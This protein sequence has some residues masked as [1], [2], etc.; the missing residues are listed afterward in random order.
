MFALHFEAHSTPSGGT[1]EDALVRRLADRWQLSASPS[2]VHWIP[3][4]LI[5]A[6]PRRAGKAWVLA[7]HPGHA[8]DV[9]LVH[10]LRAPEGGLLEVTGVHNVT[11]TFAADESLLAADGELAAWAL[12]GF[13]QCFRVQ[14][15]DIGTPR[16]LPDSF[17]DTQRWKWRLAWYQQTGELHGITLRDFKLDPPRA[18]VALTV[19]QGTLTIDA[20]DRIILPRNQPASVGGRFVQESTRP[21]A[22]PGNT[23]TWA[24]DRVRALRWFGDERMQWVKAVAYRAKD[25]VERSLSVELAVS[26][27]TTVFRTHLDSAISATADATDPDS[28]A[29]FNPAW[30]PQALTPLLDPAWDGEGEWQSLAGDPFVRAPTGLPSSFSTTFIRVDRDRKFSRVMI[31]AW[32]PSVVELHM[33]SGTEEPKSATGATGPGRIPREPAILRRLVGAFNGGFQGTHGDFGM[34][35]DRTLYVPPRPYAATVARLD[36]GT[37]A[38]GTWP[39]RAPVPANVTSFRQ[40]LSP[41][42]VG[43]R[44]NP[45]GRLWWGGVPEGWKDDTQTVR[46]GLC[47]TR[48]GLI[49]YFY[50]T[51]TDAE[52]LS[53]AMATA[54]CEYGLHLDMNQGH[55]GLEFYLVD[56]VAALPPMAIAPHPVWQAEGSLEDAPGYRFR[57]RRLFRGMQL[58]NFPRYIGVEARDFFYLTLRPLLPGQ[59][60]GPNET[61]RHSDA[62]TEGA[63]QT[64]GLPQHG[65]PFAIARTSV[66]P[67][68]DH[69]EAKL[70]LVK[71]D[72]FR[73]EPTHAHTDRLIASWQSTEAL[74][75]SLGIWW[76]AGS[77]RMS[78]HAPNQEATLIVS[79]HLDPQQ[80]VASAAGITTDGMLVIAEIATGAPG[81]VRETAALLRRGLDWAG[82][83]QVVYPSA[84]LGVVIGGRDLSLHPKFPPENALHLRRSDRPGFQSIFKDT[85]VVEREVWRPLHN[86]IASPE[87]TTNAQAQPAD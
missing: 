63:W 24:V 52:H 70:H 66:R 45:Y 50:G 60:V 1:V 31:V 9:Y 22:P 71:L 28:N 41:L 53:K 73:F 69:E 82:V 87:Q 58:M 33:M 85:P 76:D 25:W 30:P 75:G 34:M 48:S 11:E 12:G 86:R 44:V 55:T 4:R 46:S 5:S 62:Q 51:K 13:G 80:R 3:P 79:G 49:A 32:D 14:L 56:E 35:V 40:N 6:A 57:G 27:D 83:S 38:F 64:E 81:G 47:L 67:D 18:H 2:D 59:H 17:D 23:L 65:R 20:G 10:V 77:L 42:V 72:P 43:D 7:Q 74:P 8:N 37:T 39:S 15:A 36:D 61:A 29:P 78:S 54:D 21:L 68:P 84:P 19:E 26:D 16:Q